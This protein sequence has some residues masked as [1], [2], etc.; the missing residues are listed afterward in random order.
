[1]GEVR[2]LFLPTRTSNSELCVGSFSLFLSFGETKERKEIAE[3]D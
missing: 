2:Y 1:L 3:Y